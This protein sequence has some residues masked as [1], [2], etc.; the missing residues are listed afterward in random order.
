M[1]AD[2]ER[3]VAIVKQIL[4]GRI[5]GA[6]SAKALGRSSRTIRRYLGARGVEGSS[7]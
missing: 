5:S 2:F 3:K 7:A 4:E 1:K 6:V